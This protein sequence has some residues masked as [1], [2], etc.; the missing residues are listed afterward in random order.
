M[1]ADCISAKSRALN[2]ALK[3]YNNRALNLDFSSFMDAFN[4]NF[5]MFFFLCQGVATGEGTVHV[6]LH[7]FSC[8]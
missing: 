8:H 7:I 4:C 6:K 3:C 5:T 1:M 2:R